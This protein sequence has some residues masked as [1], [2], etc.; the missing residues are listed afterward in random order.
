ML[1]GSEDTTVKLWD[2]KHVAES[3]KKQSGTQVHPTS[4]FSGHT[5]TVEDVDWHPKDMNMVA[6]VGDD[7]RICLWDVRNPGTKPI[8]MVTDAHTSD[9]NCIAFNPVV[10]HCF[11]TGSAGTYSFRLSARTSFAGTC[12][13]PITEFLSNFVDKTVAIWDT[14]NISKCLNSLVSHSDEVLCVDWAPF[15]ESILASCSADRRVALW[16]LSRIGQEQTPEDAE[17]GPPE[18]LF[19][20]GGHTSKVS[21]FSWNTKDEWTIAS[22]SEDNVLQVWNI[23]EEIYA[24]DGEDKSVEDLEDGML[25]EDELEG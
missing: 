25:G 5:A 4:S 6:S 3:M 12:L 20:H 22:V 1:T 10:E 15:N 19:L 7:R 13:S 21:D 18:L 17:D 23:A 11:A 8:H 2:V 14:R 9:I 24:Q 16:D